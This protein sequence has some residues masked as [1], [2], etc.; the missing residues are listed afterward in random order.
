M[1]KKQ[2]TYQQALSEIEAI[3]DEIENGN[4]DVD[5]IAE[6]I[7]KAVNLVKFCKENLRKTS[8]E[9]DAALEELED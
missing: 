4:P 3:V 7:S 1:A 5:Q 2:L 6:K 9:L 8:T